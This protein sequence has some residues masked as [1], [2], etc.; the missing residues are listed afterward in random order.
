M[1]DDRTYLRH[2]LDAIRKIEEY[3]R[4]QTA[5]SLE[6]DTKTLDAVV[7]ELEI[8]GEAV[9]HLSEAF[10][11]THS[12]IPY[13]DIIGMRNRLIHEYFDVDID[14]VVQTCEEDIPSLKAKVLDVLRDA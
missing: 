12:G 7:R 1:K 10:R 6:R 5:K 9:T 4:G 3:M 11:K 14:A 8:I 13:P 2:V